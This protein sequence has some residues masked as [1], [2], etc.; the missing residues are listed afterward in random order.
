MVPSQPPESA[1]EWVPIERLRPW[2]DNPRDNDGAVARVAASI[3]RFGFGAPIIARR[4]DGE[5]IAGHTRLKAAAQLGLPTVPVRY[6]DL[7][8]VDAHLLAIADNKT[9]EL[10]SWNDERLIDVLRSFKAEDLADTGFSDLELK[11]LL[12]DYESPFVEGER[13]DAD[14]VDEGK[15]RI[16]LKVLLVQAARARTVIAQAL[17]DQ[18]IEFEFA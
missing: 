3:K 9:N 16:A 5:V 4:A 17:S 2:G 7:D 11:A 10:A 12:A 18:G 15:E 6:L 8:P 14:I 1:A 13:P